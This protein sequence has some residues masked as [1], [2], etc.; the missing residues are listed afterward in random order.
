[1]GEN[2]YLMWLVFGVLVAGLLVLDLGVFHRKAHVV[3]LKEALLFSLGWISLALIFNGFVWYEMGHV[4]ALEFLT[5]Y[6]IEESLSV[7]NLFVFI[8]I[9]SYF[10]VASIHHHRIL[11]WGIVGAIVMRA[12]FI[13]SGLTLIARF[14]WIIYVFGIFLVITGIKML[15]YKEQEIHPE[16]NIFVRLFKKFVPIKTDY[17]G[18]DFITRE[19]GKLMAT[20]LLVVLLVVE[21]TDVMFAVDSIPAIFAITNDPFIVYTSNIFAILGLRSLYFLLA[22]IIDRFQYLKV[23]LAFVLTFV[24]IKML[25]SEFY[26]IP[27]AIALGVVAAILAA[28]IVISLVKKPKP[29]EG[30]DP[31]PR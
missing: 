29:L 30:R 25:I 23:G 18:K 14:H 28:S 20:P 9:F 4:K 16:K 3:K 7:D 1:M 15:L 13:A 26:K 10:G 11:F 24:G 8:V 27:I 22:D 19:N 17:E 2:Q 6:L 31:S 21:T 5:G 12:I